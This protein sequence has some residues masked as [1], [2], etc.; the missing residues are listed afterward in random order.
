MQITPLGDSAVIISVGPKV[1]LATVEAGLRVAEALG[2]K[3]LAGVTD[4]VPAFNTVTVH[5]DVSRVPFAATTPLAAVETWI[6][7]TM[8]KAGKRRTGKP[9]EF[10][11]PVCY[12]GEDGPDMADVALHTKLTEA[13]IIKLHTGGSYTVA[14]LGFAP[15]FP[16]LMGLSPKLHMPR[17]GTPRLAVPVGS[18]GI[19]GTH[20]GVYSLATPGGWALIGQTPWRLFRPEE[21]H[22]PTLLAAGDTVRFK[23]ISRKDWGAHAEKIPAPGNYKTPKNIAVVEVVKAGVLTTVQDMGREGWQ[24]LGITG[25]GA[26]DRRAA[27]IANLLLG[28]PDD[29][30]VLEATLVGPELKFLRDTWIAVTGAEVRGVAGWRPLKIE[31]GDTLSLAELT[32]G[33]R[34]YIAVAGGFDVPRVLGGAG[35]LLRAAMGGWNGRALQVGDR[36][37]ARAVSLVTDGRWAAG[38]EFRTARSGEVRARFVR[39]GQWDRFTA[40]AH[41]A[42]TAKSYRIT[43]QSDRMGLRLE[44]VAL[45][46]TSDEPLTSEG[47]G[48]GTVQVPADGQPIVLMADRQTIGGY[49]KIGH[50]IAVDLPALAQARAGDVINFEEISLADAQVLAIDESRALSLLREGIRA[51]LR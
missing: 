33:S 10:I 11:V 50:V 42:F 43:P 41:K 14:A 48:F 39:G 16:Y 12:G 25:G 13:E 20:T 8:A 45:K 49:P 36:L 22:A 18:V 21:I 28:N 17:R 47:V 51:K 3:P 40:A 1:D 7:A 19:G 46:L 9:K 32:R 2:G 26:M 6:K 15:G 27:R 30:P 23:A 4:I 5:Y 38:E 37:A 24:H 35:T 34:V 31:A 44:G 29:A